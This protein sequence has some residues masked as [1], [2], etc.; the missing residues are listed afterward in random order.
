MSFHLDARNLD[1]PGICGF[2]QL[3][4]QTSINLGAGGKSL[5]QFQQAD[6]RSQGGQD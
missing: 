4:Q 5:I 1:A 3:G 2:V 6:F